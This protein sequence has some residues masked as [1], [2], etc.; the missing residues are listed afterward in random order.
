MLLDQLHPEEIVSGS[1]DMLVLHGAG[2]AFAPVL[3][4]S[5]MTIIG[6]HG[7]PLY[8]ALVLGLLAGFAVY[9]RKR[10]SDLVSG[11]SAHFEP[12]VQTSSQALNMMFDDSQPD[13]FKDRSFYDEKEQTRIVEALKQSMNNA[14]Q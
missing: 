7:L 9:R 1:S 11:N 14:D 10:V 8:I 3:A 2:C 13:L 12:M 6:S 4:G 5:L